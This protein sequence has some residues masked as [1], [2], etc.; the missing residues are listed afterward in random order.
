MYVITKKNVY[1]PANEVYFAY[2]IVEAL[3]KEAALK[4]AFGLEHE[5]I[6]AKVL[7]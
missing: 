1:D 3:H 6:I 2:S 4:Q 7:D 5:W